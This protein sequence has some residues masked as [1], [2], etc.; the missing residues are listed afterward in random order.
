[1]E[2]KEDIPKI[3]ADHE[4]RLA[5]LESLLAKPISPETTVRQKQLASLPDR[6]IQL[7]ESGFFVHPRTADDVH[8]KL[9]PT[10]HC[11]PDRVAM[12][13]LRLAKRKELRKAA[14][15]LEERKYQA[16]VW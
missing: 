9:S 12:A 1:M 14:K 13:L 15:K 16:Y 11:Q 5:K 6:I 8:K 3:L 10:Y 2:T 4:R 7:R